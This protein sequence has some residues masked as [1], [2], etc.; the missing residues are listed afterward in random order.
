M[1][2]LLELVAY[3]VDVDGVLVI[4]V[5]MMEDAGFRAEVGDICMK[6]ELDDA[7]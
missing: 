1:L 3:A 2:L 6:G 4:A 7:G 5:F